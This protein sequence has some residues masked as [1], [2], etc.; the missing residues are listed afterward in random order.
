MTKYKL[1]FKD[2]DP[3]TGDI[4]Q[5]EEI[6]KL[7]CEENTLQ[8]IIYSLNSEGMNPN[9]DFYYE[10]ISN[11]KER[12][13][14]SIELLN[15][16]GPILVAKKKNNLFHIIDEHKNTIAILYEREIQSFVHGDMMIHKNEEKKYWK[17]S[18]YPGDMKPD[19]KKLDEF[20]GIDT[21]DKTY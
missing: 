11:T 9:R 16:E 17:Y 8:W 18:E 20:I 15:S 10:E 21:T 12:K 2:V 14:N 4:S 1:Y 3:D 19:L 7:E 6:A 5:F 13:E